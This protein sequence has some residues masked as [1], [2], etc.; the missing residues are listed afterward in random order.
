MYSL[1]IGKALVLVAVSVNW[2]SGELPEPPIGVPFSEAWVGPEWTQV[3]LMLT[4]VYRDGVPREIR[5][6]RGL[7]TAAPHYRDGRIAGVG[8]RFEPVPARPAALLPAARP[9]HAARVLS[10]A[11]TPR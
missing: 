11:A 5:M 4:A 2:R 3:L 8:T 6:V 1:F 10:R 9:R 7:L